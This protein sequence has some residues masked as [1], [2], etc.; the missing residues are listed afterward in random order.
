MTG[1]KLQFINV[2]LMFLQFQTFTTS[3]EI[4]SHTTVFN[5]NNMNAY[6]HAIK[7]N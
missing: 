2:C 7:L 5:N 4:L 3:W 1:I 6:E